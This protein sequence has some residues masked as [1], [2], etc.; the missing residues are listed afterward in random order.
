VIV[1]FVLMWV[2]M[3]LTG[4]SFH[5]FSVASFHAGNILAM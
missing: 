4:L 5:V 3:A 2:G 1:S